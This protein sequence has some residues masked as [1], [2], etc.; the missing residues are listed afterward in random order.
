[1]LK[2]WFGR[3]LELRRNQVRSCSS[4][5]RQVYDVPRHYKVPIAGS[6]FLAGHYR[7]ILK[8]VL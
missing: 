4:I 7:D 2:V 5:G 6:R 1:M 8:T 3:L